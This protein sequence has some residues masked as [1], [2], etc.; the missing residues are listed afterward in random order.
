MA[1]IVIALL[2]PILGAVADFKAA[3]KRFL[4]AFML[5]GVVATAGMFFI[6]RGELLFASALFVLSIAGAT[7]SMTFYEALLPHIPC[8]VL[9][10]QGVDDEYGTM[11]QIDGIAAA[12]PRVALLKLEA[13]GHSPH[14]DQPETLTQACFNFFTTNQP[15]H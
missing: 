1:A 8:P 13:C 3:K 4:F 5:I 11:A 15:T 7:G 2:A 9:A 6:D 10:I 12:A 14:R